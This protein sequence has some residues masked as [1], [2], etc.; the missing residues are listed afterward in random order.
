MIQKE[1]IIQLLRKLNIFKY[2]KLIIISFFFVIF[3]MIT[4]GVNVELNKDIIQIENL[5][6]NEKQIAIFIEDLNK[7]LQYFNILMI[8]MQFISLFLM[9]LL[10]MTIRN[11]TKKT[12]YDELT[13]LLSREMF[14]KKFNIAKNKYD[15]IA[16]FF[17]DLDNFKDINDTLGHEKGDEVL[18]YISNTLKE[19]VNHEECVG[20]FGGDEFII[21]IP[22]KEQEEIIKKSKELL[23]K[24]NREIELTKGNEKYKY[25]ISASIGIALY[26]EHSNDIDKLIK[27]ADTAMY[28]K[29][30]DTKNGIFFYSNGLE[31]KTKLKIKMKNSLEIAIAEEK[32]KIYLQ[33]QINK[34]ERLVGAE[35]LI[36]WD[37]GGKI[38]PPG[39]FLSI[40]AETGL[41]KNIDIFVVKKVTEQLKKWLKKGY[42][43]GIISINLTI[44]NLERPGFIEE[45]EKII[46]NAGIKA[47]HI[48]LEIT[49]ESLMSEKNI[50]RNLEI[51]N[52]L[53]RKG[54][55][56]SID[57][58]G[59]GYSNISYLKKF[60]VDKLKI[61]KEFIKDLPNLKD[62]MILKAMVNLGNALGYSL[63]A[64]GVETEEQKNIVF[65][66]GIDIIQGYY[67]SKPISV[68]EFEQK[69]LKEKGTI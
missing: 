11:I 7:Y 55:T 21:F 27:Q 23:K 1:K 63:I 17:L 50:K 69:W 13:G 12:Y 39:E 59:T 28:I 46:Q 43:P 58:F 52:K 61:D 65:D 68:E 38:L 16:I 62:E 34:E 33:P 45:M 8:L 26:D 10:M 22:Y 5:L 42:N 64:E 60:N 49:E 31:N 2:E 30:K 15:K 53:K 37:V 3:T 56:I 47:H 54:F 66:L 14:K 57:D 41:I 32:L 29:K 36:R 51:I 35:T 4:I 19:F 40:A 25:K 20:R 6:L 44:K 48:G 18:L 9:V 67:F 24:L